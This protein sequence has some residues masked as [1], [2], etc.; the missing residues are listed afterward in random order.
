MPHHSA[1]AYE[2]NI[3]G[4]VSFSTRYMRNDEQMRPRKPMYAVV[5]NSCTRQHNARPI[6]LV[7]FT[8][9]MYVYVGYNVRITYL[10]VSP[11]D[12]TQ[13]FPRPTS[14]VDP[15]HAQDLEESQTT[16]SGS[17]EHFSVCSKRQDDDACSDNNY[18]CTSINM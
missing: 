17:G 12:G 13:Q 15:H 8:V 1:S 16:Q 7:I 18:I 4:L 14:S 10:P 11:D 6:A 2:A 5:N 3:R 9:H